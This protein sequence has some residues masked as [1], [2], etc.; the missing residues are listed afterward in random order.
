MA[1]DDNRLRA[2]VELEK[3]KNNLIEKYKTTFKVNGSSALDADKASF[4]GIKSSDECCLELI[5]NIN[6]STKRGLYFTSGDVPKMREK[7]VVSYFLKKNYIVGSRTNKDTATIFLSWLGPNY[8]KY[9]LGDTK[10][11]NLNELADQV[12]NLILTDSL[13][14]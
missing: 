3:S 5:E 1:I 12:K 11:K 8:L 9:H 14:C 4:K 13:R 7:D 10:I 2:K 6:D